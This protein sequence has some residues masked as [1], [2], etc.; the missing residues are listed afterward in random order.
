[1][2]IDERYQS[3]LN[4]ENSLLSDYSLVNLRAGVRG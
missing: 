3:A 2:W 1:M 4:S